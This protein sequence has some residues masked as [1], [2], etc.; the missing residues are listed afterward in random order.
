MYREH[1]QTST[2]TLAIVVLVLAAASAAATYGL[3]RRDLRVAHARLAGASE[4]VT[5]RCGPIEY[6][7]L[8]TG[9]PLLV[10]HGAGGGFDQGLE[11]GAPIAALGF[12]VVAVSRFGYL[13]T[14]LPSD[15]S[16]AAQADA[17]ACLLDALGLERAAVLGISAGG[18][19]AI[20][21]AVRHPH[22][23][24]ALVLLVPATFV[25]RPDGAAP[26]RVPPGT[27]QLFDTALR[28]DFLFWTIR[29]AAPSL[30]HR[31]VL[32]TPPELVARA[33]L[34]ERTRVAA[35]L[36]AILPV[37]ERR[38]G[39]LNDAHV[40]TRLERAPLETIAVP[41]LTISVADDLYGTYD[42]ARYTAEHIP[43]ARFVGYTEGGHV[44]VGHEA[45]VVTTIASFLREP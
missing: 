18:P 40:T 13:R 3:Y 41:T 6:A 22:R 26:V 27:R 10:V 35:I 32:G 29:H 16:A 12:N 14:P 34:A 44:F 15:A 36:D 42:A 20:E 11:I 33:T 43:G 23:V 5:T 8:G 31:A 30:M 45:K 38:L 17:H 24:A 25:P 1:V 4:L 21:L 2:R 28:S 39:L 9:P 37:S 7:T 19:S